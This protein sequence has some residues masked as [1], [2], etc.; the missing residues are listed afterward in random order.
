[1]LANY[2]IIKVEND[3]ATVSVLCPKC[4]NAVTTFQVDYPAF[5]MYTKT[6]CHVQD[7]FPHETPMFRELLITG[8]CLK[9]QDEFFKEPEFWIY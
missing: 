7:L 8:M 3:I 4:K 9:C 2:E 1:M 6:Y 5:K